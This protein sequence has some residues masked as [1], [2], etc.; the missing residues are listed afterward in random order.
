MTKE[1]Y[2]VSPLSFVCHNKKMKAR[3]SSVS[4]AST[5]RRKSRDVDLLVPGYEQLHHAVSLTDFPLL[6]NLIYNQIIY[7]DLFTENV[8]CTPKLVC[9]R[10]SPDSYDAGFV[11]AAS[12]NTWSTCALTESGRDIAC[13]M[14]MSD[15]HIIPGLLIRS[16]QDGESWCL[17][18][19]GSHH[20]KG[21]L[22]EFINFRRLAIDLVA[23][24]ILPGNRLVKVCSTPV[25]PSQITLRKSQGHSRVSSFFTGFCY[26][27]ACASLH[28]CLNLLE[29]DVE[30][31]GC[32]EKAE[33]VAKR[34]FYIDKPEVVIYR[35]LEVDVAINPDLQEIEQRQDLCAAVA[36]W[37]VGSGELSNFASEKNQIIKAIRRSIDKQRRL[38]I[39]LTPEVMRDMFPPEALVSDTSQ[40]SF[41]TLDEV[42]DSQS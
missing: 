37:L 38:H 6:S 11:T 41:E 25:L 27:H 15:D 3:A 32:E 4:A 1:H 35:G 14:F 31:C 30:R 9:F 5:T 22:Q 33:E 16:N 36:R 23:T 26:L 24:Q 8:K 40:S 42:S 39:S 13:V 20:K 17:C 19:S 34:V 10:A 2:V 28:V 29:M 18:L 7:A 21:A 12:Y